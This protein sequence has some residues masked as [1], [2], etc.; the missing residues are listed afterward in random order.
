MGKYIKALEEDVAK[1][2]EKLTSYHAYTP[3]EV[4]HHN[5]QGLFS[6]L[7]FWQYAYSQLMRQL[8]TKYMR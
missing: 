4:F 3:D 6:V 7:D 8:L 5:G 2:K 1:R